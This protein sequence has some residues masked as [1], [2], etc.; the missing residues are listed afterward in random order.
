MKGVKVLNREEIGE[1][2]NYWRL[3]FEGI[4]VKML[5]WLTEES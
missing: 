3:Y 1:R 5:P 4:A 2:K